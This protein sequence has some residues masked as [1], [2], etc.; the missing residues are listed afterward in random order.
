MDTKE[1]AVRAQALSKALQA[2]EPAANISNLLDELR[3]GVRATEDL[4]RTTKIGVI[5]NRTKQHKD[6]AVARKGSE[7]V[8]KWKQDVRKGGS[9]T[10]SSTPRSNANGTASPAPGAAPSP[11]PAALVKPKSKLSVAPSERNSK[12]DKVDTNLTGNPARDGCIKLMYDGLAHMSEESP[13]DVLRMARSVELAAF[14]AHNHETSAD[15]KTK[16]RSLYQN[17]KNKSNPQLRQRVLSGEITPDRFVV[18]TH[19]ELKSESRKKEDAALER[20]NLNKA[21]VAQ[22]ERS[23]SASLTCGKCGQKKVSYSQ[24][25]TRSAD[26]PMT[27]FCE[28]TNCGHRWKFS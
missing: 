25:Q 23:I 28:C 27:T 15:Y 1:V 12:A 9:G 16:M 4:L 6:P 3:K 5:V 8:S 18:M 20:E 10:G 22:V 21:M 19:E 11:K 14:N 2:D 13:E 17:L 24:A 26:E 7:L